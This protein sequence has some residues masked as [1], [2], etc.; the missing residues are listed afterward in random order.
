MNTHSQKYH[1]LG[2]VHQPLIN[3][4]CAGCPGIWKVPGK[5]PSELG[6]YQAHPPVGSVWCLE[7]SNLWS[8]SDDWRYWYRS[9]TGTAW[10]ATTPWG[11][12]RCAEVPKYDAMQQSGTPGA[13]RRKREYARSL[14]SWQR[15]VRL[16]WHGNLISSGKK[17]D[18]DVDQQI[19]KETV[20]Y[21]TL[22]NYLHLEKITSPKTNVWSIGNPLVFED[23]GGL[24]CWG[25]Q[26]KL[27]KHLA[28]LANLSHIIIPSE[29]STAPHNG[30][31]F[32]CTT[33][34]FDNL[35]EQIMTNQPSNDHPM[36]SKVSLNFAKLL[37]PPCKLNSLDSP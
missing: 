26:V 27:Y 30:G 9:I 22:Q 19:G 7:N 34:N 18:L 4:R 17:N 16:P 37:H 14:N 20:S 28:N 33:P 1:L 11:G 15:I 29:V 8:S 10:R 6:K 25:N 21:K 5:V 32:T 36:I 35:N 31:T 24:P 12:R 13:S 2:R 3:P 23:V